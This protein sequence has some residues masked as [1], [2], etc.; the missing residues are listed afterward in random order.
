MTFKGKCFIK[1]VSLPKREPL[2]WQCVTKGHQIVVHLES[3]SV[4]GMR[5][6]NH[7]AKKSDNPLSNNGL[8]QYVASVCK[9]SAIHMKIV[10][11][12]T[13]N[14]YHRCHRMHS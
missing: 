4:D 1:H 6:A 3:I 10:I 9:M 14:Y 13:D 7:K 12:T 2:A 11:L 5:L 8:C